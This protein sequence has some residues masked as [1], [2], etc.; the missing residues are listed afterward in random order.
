MST[1]LNPL[2]GGEERRRPRVDDVREVA[3]SLFAERGYHGTSMSQIAE[4]V[5]VRLPTLDSHIR[6]N[7]EILVE[8]VVETTDVVLVDFERAIS[9]IDD[10]A[11]RLRRAIEAYAF[12]HATHPTEALV[13]NRDVFSLDEPI[14]SS[15]LDSRR[16]HE[17][18]IRKIL[19]EGI[20]AG[21]FDVQSPAIASFAML[22]MSVSIARWFHED[23]Q[24]SGC[25]VARLYSE[26][27]LSIAKSGT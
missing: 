9:G 3:L 5:G 27:A 8:I 20:E 6:S 16:R 11:E 23:G 4:V 1:R 15:V 25:D 19:T 2:T 24:L 26:F 10:V 13:V 14:R 18:G 21:V 17:H 7:Q 22:E 12:R